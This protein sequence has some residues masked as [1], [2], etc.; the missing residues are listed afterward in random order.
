MRSEFCNLLP[1]LAQHTILEF[2]DYKLRCGKYIKR[3]PKDLPIYKYILNRPRIEEEYY[4]WDDWRYNT[5]LYKY[6]NEDGSYVIC[7]EYG[8]TTYFMISLVIGT[9]KRKSWLENTMEISYSSSDRNTFR[10]QL[11]LYDY[12]FDG[13]KHRVV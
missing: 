5:I 6:D 8:Y 4:S 3:L 13:S 9:I 10:V 7:D 11:H 12:D 1:D 2:L